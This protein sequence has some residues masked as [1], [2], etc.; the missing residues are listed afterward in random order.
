M[1]QSTGMELS[2]MTDFIWRD[3]LTA[4]SGSLRQRNDHFPECW[5]E[6]VY[7]SLHVQT[8]MS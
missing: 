8:E 7:A 5:I 1:T 6:A 3:V 2:L 4:L